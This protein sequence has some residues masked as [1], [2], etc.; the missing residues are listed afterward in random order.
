MKVWVD[1]TGL[2]RGTYDGRIKI[3]ASGATNSPQTIFVHV[4]RD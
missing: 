2:P 3:W 1:G 4:T